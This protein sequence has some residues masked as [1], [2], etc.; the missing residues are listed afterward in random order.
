MFNIPTFVLQ[1]HDLGFYVHSLLTLNKSMLTQQNIEDGARFINYLTMAKFEVL[2]THTDLTPAE[3]ER[4]ME[5][6]RFLVLFLNC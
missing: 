5:V 6:S 4:Q 3:T 1:G 2:S